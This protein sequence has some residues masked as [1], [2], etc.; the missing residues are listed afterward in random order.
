MH[1]STLLH[2]LRRSTL[3]ALAAL[4]VA[5][6]AFADWTIYLSGQMGIG[7]TTADIRGTSVRRGLNGEG[8]PVL[9]LDQAGSDTTPAIGMSLGV[10][11]PLDELAP[12]N[13]PFGWRPPDWK[14][15]V[16][17]EFTGLRQVEA[18]TTGFTNVDTGD[19]ITAFPV[20]FSEASTWNFSVN[21]WQDVPLRLLDR[22]I[23]KLFGRTPRS[24]SK[25]LDRTDF[26]VGGGVGF[27]SLSFSSIDNLH[28]GQG[29]TINFAWQVG[30]GFSYEL[31]SIVALEAGYRYVDSGTGRSSFFDSTTAA[32]PVNRGPYSVGLSSHEGRFALRV[33]LYSFLNPWRNI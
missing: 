3:G 29:D 18:R 5:P 7:V 16:E 32:D 10:Q 2:A 27:S 12:W 13:L 20:M 31:T 6:A 14:T 22:P 23:A 33:L 8:V 24:V 15:R 9:L 21:L 26:Q 17:V 28:L 30:T 4:F 25:F 11:M 1:R 19:P